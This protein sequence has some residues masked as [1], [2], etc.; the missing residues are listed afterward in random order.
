MLYDGVSGHS[1]L[2]VKPKKHTAGPDNLKNAIGYLAYPNPTLQNHI[3][4]RLFYEYDRLHHSHAPLLK[5]LAAY[6]TSGKL[7]QSVTKA[8]YVKKI[9][10]IKELLA[11]GEVYQINYAIRFRKKLSGDPYA[12]FHRLASTNPASF[13]AYLNC[14]NFH[15]LSCSPERLFKTSGDTIITQPIKGTISKSGGRNAL[16]KLLNNEKE[17]AELDMITDLERNDIGK[18]CR[19]STLKLTKE[20]EVMELPNLWHTYSEVRGKLSPHIRPSQILAAL[21]P[22]GSITGCP[23]LRAMEY[24]ETLERLPRNIFTGSIGYLSHGVMDFNIAIRT[25]LIHNGIVEYWAGGGIVYDSD[26]EKEYAECLL[27][28]EKFLALLC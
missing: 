25:A 20:R 12:L 5:P 16:A 15:I 27:K 21:F 22:G 6:S 18:I 23:K 14:G 1:I 24:I 26:P 17:R 10:Q 13:S 28:A 9:H 19:Y 2:G 7:T 8:Q 3:P 11:A 4:N